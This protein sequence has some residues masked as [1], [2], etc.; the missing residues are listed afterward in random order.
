MSATQTPT[1]ELEE[2][3]RFM[4]T[5][6]ASGL[7]KAECERIVY[8]KGLPKDTCC[9]GPEKY[10][11]KLFTLICLEA[12]GFMNPLNPDP[13]RT[14]LVK[15]DRQNLTRFVDDYLSKRMPLMK[16]IE[17]E[18][19]KSMKKQKKKGENNEQQQH[20]LGPNAEELFAIKAASSSKEQLKK[21]QTLTLSYIS[22]L[23][24]NAQALHAVIHDDDSAKGS[25]VQ[26][27]E[28]CR[29]VVRETEKF[30]RRFCKVLSAAG[31]ASSK[32]STT[33]EESGVGFTLGMLLIISLLYTVLISIHNTDERKNSD[34]PMTHRKRFT[35]QLHS[36][37]M[38]QG[39][40]Q[41]NSAAYTPVSGGVPVIPPT[42]VGLPQ[43]PK[44]FHYK[45]A[46]GQQ[47][48]GS[49]DTVKPIRTIGVSRKGPPPPTKPKPTRKQHTTLPQAVFLL[50]FI[51]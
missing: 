42:I 1:E 28:A 3:F 39:S 11:V 44:P 13:L 34:S 9:P 2:E 22:R 36:P 37:S 27:E 5:Q 32:D 7:E 12:R 25:Q 48:V 51:T 15:I 23:M 35:H 45:P 30:N 4:I 40:R 17:K 49:N 19:K 31:I 18:R 38:E 10:D 14:L 6:V 41:P 33:S 26:K 16:K 47:H 20:Q 43:S 29:A 21:L 46:A 24:Q 8:L 50:C